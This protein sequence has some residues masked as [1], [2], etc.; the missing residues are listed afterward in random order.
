[1]LAWNNTVHFTELDKGRLKKQRQDTERGFWAVQHDNLDI[2]F[3]TQGQTFFHSSFRV[4]TFRRY[5]LDVNRLSLQTSSFSLWFC[6]FTTDDR[7]P[8]LSPAHYTTS[9]KKHK[10]LHIL[11]VCCFYNSCMTG[12]EVASACKLMRVYRS[13][14]WVK[15]RLQCSKSGFWSPFAN[16]AYA[17]QCFIVL[18]PDKIQ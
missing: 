4:F 18:V 14:K 3:Q 10:V 6:K 11:L 17:A 12:T 16:K 5:V 13:N 8:D 7:C 9:H 1:M 2:H 15:K